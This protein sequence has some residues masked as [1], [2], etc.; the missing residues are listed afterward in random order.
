MVFNR[1]WC[2]ID[3]CRSTQ[4]VDDRMVMVVASGMACD[5]LYMTYW[6][7]IPLEEAASLELALLTPQRQW[8]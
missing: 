3:H 1:T 2:C 6:K 4:G 7:E 8:P 5:L